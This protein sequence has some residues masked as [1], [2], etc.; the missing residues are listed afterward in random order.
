MVGVRLHERE[1][2]GVKVGGGQRTAVRKS[3]GLVACGHL[4][5]GTTS[6]N[7]DVIVLSLAYL[8]FTK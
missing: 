7:S 1:K 5:K 2:M 8:K 6:H 4:L 3:H